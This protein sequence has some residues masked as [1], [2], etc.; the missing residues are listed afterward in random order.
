MSLSRVLS[1]KDHAARAGRRTEYVVDTT[2]WEGS[3]SALSMSSQHCVYEREG[4]VCVCVCV[5]V[6]DGLVI[7]ACFVVVIPIIFVSC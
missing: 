5:C 1:S 4:C 2:S 3:V 6:C 7:L